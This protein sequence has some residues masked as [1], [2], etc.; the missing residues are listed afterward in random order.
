MCSDAVGRDAFVAFREVK[1]GFGFAS[2]AAHTAFAVDDDTAAQNRAGS[3]QWSESQNCG[4]GVAARIRDE[5]GALDPFAVDFRQAVHDIAEPSGVRMFQAIP[6]GIFG[7]VVEAVIG[8]KVD[9][10]LAARQ[11]FLNGIGAC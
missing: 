1:V 3:K 2:G 4:S 6:G 10:L 5:V 11:E 7:G 8:A 9:N